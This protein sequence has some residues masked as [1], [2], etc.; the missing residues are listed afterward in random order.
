MGSP[1]VAA[2]GGNDSAGR[3]AEGGCQPAG[4][5]CVRVS[6]LTIWAGQIPSKFGQGCGAVSCKNHRACPTVI[7]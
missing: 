4:A 6:T 5:F 2:P 1:L 7:G 3:I